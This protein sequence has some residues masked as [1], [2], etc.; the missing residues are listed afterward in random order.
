[1]RAA[2]SEVEKLSGTKCP[3]RRGKF[4]QITAGIGHGNGRGRPTNFGYPARVMKETAER[5]LKNPDLEAVAEAQSSELTV[6][7]VRFIH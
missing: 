6:D 2:L 1:M 4:T 3:E 5:L 7:W